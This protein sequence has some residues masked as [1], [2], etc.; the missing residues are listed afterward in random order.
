MTPEQYEH[1]K[2][3]SR[4][5]VN[6]VVSA[7]KREPSRKKVRECIGFFFSCRMDPGDEWRRVEDWDN[8]ARSENG[9]YGYCC[10]DH[11]SDMAEYWIPGYWALPC[12]DEI[13][14]ERARE[15]YVDPVSAC[16]RSGLDVAVSPSAG[17]CGF[18]AGDIRS[19]YPEGVPQWVKEFFAAPAENVTLHET[20][21]EGIYVPETEPSEY[22]TF[23][24][25]PDGA[26]VWL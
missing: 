15:R 14:Y 5:M 22:A 6:V 4:R 25:I 9:H 10:S 3:F 21:I 19:M 16:I 11:I 23:D 13:A 24:D 1:W 12:D 2:D 20:N 17:V 18:T 26:E 7:R 8:T